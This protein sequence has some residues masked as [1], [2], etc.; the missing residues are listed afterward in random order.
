M[1]S[2]A[3]CLLSPSCIFYLSSRTLDI[4]LEVVTRIQGGSVPLAM[5][6]DYAILKT[7]FKN[8]FATKIGLEI[9]TYRGENK[10]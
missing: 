8:T 9:T 2:T 6:P 1:R 10:S 4:A 5:V 7:L 3:H